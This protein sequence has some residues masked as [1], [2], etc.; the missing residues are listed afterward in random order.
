MRSIL[1]CPTVIILVLKSLT[2]CH[3]FSIVFPEEKHILRSGQQIP[4]M[5]H[6][7]PGVGLRQVRYYW[8]R[9]D[10]EPLGTQH[11]EA[12]LV[13]T[14]ASTPTY[15]G[16]LKVPA[17]ALGLMR[18]LAVGDVTGG[19]L[20]G[21]ED[22]DE[23]VVHVQPSAELLAI[24][25]GVEKPWRLTTIGRIIPLTV[26]GQF[27][28]QL[29]RQLTGGSTGN[30]YSSSNEDVVRVTSDGLVQ[31]MGNGKAVLTVGNG[32]VEGTLD[33][34]VTADAE[35]NRPPVARVSDQII[36]KA[37]SVVTLNGLESS[38]PDGDPLR[39][40]W[41]QTRGNKVT[42]MN[43]DEAKA[44]FIA[45]PV[46]TRKFFQFKFRVTDMRGPDIVKGAD[47]QSKTVDVWVEP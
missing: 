11:A 46:S 4:I 16:M 40:E 8:Y 13:G 26:I 2:I 5:V 45:P 37:S 22:F 19:R 35:P 38:D 9:E 14:I 3:A 36:A 28:D 6:V 33:V 42:L 15:G 44:T 12:A 23:R 32:G 29:E 17:E 18:L 10:E 24:E 34:I 41:K 27:A 1:V 7:E 39:Y 47:S 43:M 31:V 21:R 30:L 25:F 20:A